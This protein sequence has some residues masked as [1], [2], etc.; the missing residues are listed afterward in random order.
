MSEEHAHTSY[1]KIWA[2]LLVL[3][4]VSI[5]GPE[6]GIQWVTLFTAFGI[7][8]VKAYMVAKYFMHVN[9]EHRYIPY[10]LITCIVFMML[11]FTAVAPDV[12]QSSGDNWIKPAWIADAAMDH[13]AEA[14]AEPAHH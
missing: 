10:L 7:A 5:A 13:S 1:V 12:M 4:A 14:H 6:V 11:F 3:L 9:L 8:I 2:I